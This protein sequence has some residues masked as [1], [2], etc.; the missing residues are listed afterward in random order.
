MPGAGK[1]F[2]VKEY[3]RRHGLVAAMLIVCPWNRLKCEMSRDGFRSATLHRLLG[4]CPDGATDDAAAKKTIVLK[5]I[6]H[7]H[8]PILENRPRAGVDLEV[9]EEASG[10]RL[11]DGRRPG[12]APP[13]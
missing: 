8:L 3:A 1:T 13:R 4:R 7:I 11:H 6:H 10:H 12:A 9:Y 5:V 2:A